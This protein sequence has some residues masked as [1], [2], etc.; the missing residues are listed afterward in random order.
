MTAERNSG[1]DTGAR[2]R[3]ESEPYQGASQ[4]PPTRD[5][6][7][8]RQL[9]EDARRLRAQTNTTGTSPKEAGAPLIA[10][11]KRPHGKSGDRAIRGRPDARLSIAHRLLIAEETGGSLAPQGKPDDNSTADSRRERGSPTSQRD[12]GPAAEAPSWEP[13]AADAATDNPANAPAPTSAPTPFSLFAN[14]A[15]PVSAPIPAATRAPAGLAEL[16]ERLSMMA[17]RLLVGE[18]QDGSP[19]VQIQLDDN[20]LPGVVVDMFEAD[21]SIVAQFTSADDDTRDNLAGAAPWLAQSLAS[22]LQRDALVRV[23]AERPDNPCSVEVRACPE[24]A[25]AP[26]EPSR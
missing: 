26:P 25:T 8:E 6:R 4:R 7:D 24:L 12:E 19:S 10:D 16:D 15:A 23:L 2:L 20:A 17:R 9:A 14:H 3:P 21:G 1:L 11:P 22:S 18:G 5:P 13:Q